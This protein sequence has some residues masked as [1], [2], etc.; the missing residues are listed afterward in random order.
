MRSTP[1]PALSYGGDGRR[2]RPGRSRAPD[3]VIVR[4]STE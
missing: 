3:P 1:R 2:P 4:V